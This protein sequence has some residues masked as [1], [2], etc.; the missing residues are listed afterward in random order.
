MAHLDLNQTSISSR[1]AGWG[2]KWTVDYVSNNQLI[3]SRALIQWAWNT[4]C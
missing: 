4:K 2:E 3:G 1:R